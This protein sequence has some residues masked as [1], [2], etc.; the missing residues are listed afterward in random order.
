MKKRIIKILE[1]YN[2]KEDGI[3]VSMDIEEYAKKLINSAVILT[4]DEKNKIA[5]IA[6]Y[7][8]NTNVKIGFLSMLLVDTDLR[9]IGIG[10]MLLKQAEEILKAKG[11]NKFQLDVLCKN[12]KAFSFYKRNGF[13]EL[14]RNKN[15]IKMQKDI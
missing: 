7:A 6:F 5:F 3:C 13:Y 4:Y 9:G 2:S 10:N 8:N 11:F 14:S 15:F 1:K 12:A